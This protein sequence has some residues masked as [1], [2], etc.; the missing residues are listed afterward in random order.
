M[1][2]Q[3]SGSP[4]PLERCVSVTV[5]TLVMDGGASPPWQRNAAR[6]LTDALLNVEHRT[7]GGQDHGPAPHVLAPAL[8]EFFTR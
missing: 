3:R 7:L 6:A 4:R 5:S 2:D 8:A 1:G